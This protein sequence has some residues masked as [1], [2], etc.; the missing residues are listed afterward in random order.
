VSFRS[1]TSNADLLGPTYH[2]H[3][4]ESF[5]YFD[6]FD[7]LYKLEETKGRKAFQK[8]KV[9]LETRKGGCGFPTNL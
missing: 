6:Y 4:Y 8:A 1:S 7:Y 5:D 3:R 2:Y 9:L